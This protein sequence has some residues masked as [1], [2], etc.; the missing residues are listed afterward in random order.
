MLRL[1]MTDQV[2]MGPDGLEQDLANAIRASLPLIRQLAS[3]PK[4]EGMSCTTRLPDAWW[5]I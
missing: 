5:S 1:N 2:E 3:K 4:H